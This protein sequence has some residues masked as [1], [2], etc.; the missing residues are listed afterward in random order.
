[1]IKEMTWHLGD[2]D[3][4]SIID[5]LFIS[6]AEKTLKHVLQIKDMLKWF[7]ESQAIDL[8]QTTLSLRVRLWNLLFS[9]VSSF[10][11]NLCHWF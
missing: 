9:L 5:S 7:A 11:H 8:G 6:A 3:L 4:N 2:L 1:M 10:I